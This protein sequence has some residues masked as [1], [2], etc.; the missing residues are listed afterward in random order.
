[1][2]QGSDIV[3]AEELPREFLM[4]YMRFRMENREL[5]EALADPHCQIEL[6]TVESVTETPDVAFAAVVYKVHSPKGDSRLLV[7]VSSMISPETSQPLWYIRQHEPNYTP[8]SFRPKGPSG[9][10]HAH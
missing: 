2:H 5:A 9:H 10:G 3:T 8:Q 4:H 1:M 6:E 7:V